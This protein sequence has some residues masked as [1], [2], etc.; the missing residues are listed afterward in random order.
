MNA[1]AVTDDEKRARGVP[2]YIVESVPSAERAFATHL[3][4]ECLQQSFP[5]PSERGLA[6]QRRPPGDRGILQERLLNGGSELAAR[7]RCCPV[8]RPK[9]TCPTPG[10]SP[11]EAS[12]SRSP[13][14]GYGVS[15]G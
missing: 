4:D 14:L 1:R 7:W 3:G 15:L 13:A 2:R 5:G 11:F 9:R 10:G 12:L 8:A 6:E